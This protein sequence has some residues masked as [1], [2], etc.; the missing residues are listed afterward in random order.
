MI[1][2]YP[3]IKETQTI[4]TGSKVKLQK[5][6]SNAFTKGSTK[7][8]PISKWGIVVKA[9]TDHIIGFDLGNGGEW[10]PFHNVIDSIRFNVSQTLRKS[11]TQSWLITLSICHGL[12]M[13]IP[14]LPLISVCTEQRC[15]HPAVGIIEVHYWDKGK[16]S[17]TQGT[18]ILCCSNDIID[19][20]RQGKSLTK[21]HVITAEHNL[22]HMEWKNIDQNKIDS[23]H[24]RLSGN[25]FRYPIYLNNKKM[26]CI[27][28]EYGYDDTFDCVLLPLCNPNQYP[29][30]V[31]NADHDH[32][33]SVLEAVVNAQQYCITPR[34][35]VI[36]QLGE[37]ICLVSY[38][39]GGVQTASW[40]TILKIE[41]INQRAIR[42][43]HSC[44]SADGS[45]GGLLMNSLQFCVGV[46]LG[47][48]EG[49]GYGT[50]MRSE[51]I[52]E[53][54]TMRCKLF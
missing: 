52:V 21:L 2:Y 44:R 33:T 18:G 43:Y 35:C 50:C 53:E 11:N 15:E 30:T 13:K 31:G 26:Y 49:V 36:P 10:L 12:I 8:A 51:K 23:I 39:H 6:S 7:I 48:E 1:Y 45:C 40:G 4:E 38:R 41:L 42:F 20:V 28:N 25:L 47:T 14:R 29:V 17:Y 3:D 37:P 9:E 5:I 27:D 32:F 54:L 46:H 24:F 19:I 22:K 34:S 16:Y